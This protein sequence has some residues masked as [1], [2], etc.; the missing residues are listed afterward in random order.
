MACRQIPRSGGAVSAGIRLALSFTLTSVMLLV[1]CG[2]D[3][4][5]TPSDGAVFEVRV[6]VG[7]ADHPAGETFRV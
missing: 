1:N 3:A 6:C 2:D 4:T 7:S 5:T